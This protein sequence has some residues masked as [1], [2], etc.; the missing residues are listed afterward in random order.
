MPPIRSHGEYEQQEQRSKLANSYQSL[1]NEFSS[2]EL[3]TVGN[4][5][6]GRLIG[7]GSF[8]KVYLASHKLTNGSKVVLKSAKK[9][10]AN[11]AREIHHHRQFLHPHIARLYEVIVTENLVW[12]VLEWCPGDELYNH[13]LNHGRMEPSKVQKIFTQLVGAVSYVHGKSCVHRDLKLENILL[14]KHENV[15]LV[16]FGF[17]RE[18]QGSTS[19]LQ[20]WCGTVCYSAPEM[21]K[22]EKYA[23]E[24]VDVWSLGI[25][26]HALLC[27]ELPWDEDDEAATKQLI[28]KEEPKFP[29][30]VPEQ[31]KELIKKL[32]AKRP[33]LR[34][35]LG[36]ILKDPWL[37]EHSPQQHEILKVQQPPAFSTQ[38]EKDTLQRM[39]SAGVDIDVVIE[40][41]LSQRCDALA[42]WWALLIEKEQRKER[43][44]E[45]KRKEREAEAKSIRRLSAASSRLLAQSALGEIQEGEEAAI[46]GSPSARG[47]RM[48]R[49]NGSLNKRSMDLPRVLETNSPTSERAPRDETVKDSVMRDPSRS[50]SRP[51]PP[52]KDPTI[53]LPRPRPRNVPRSNSMLRYSTVNPDLLSPAYVPPPQRKRRTFYPQ[54]LKEQLA[55]VKHWFKEGAKRAKSPSNAEGKKGKTSPQLG[56]DGTT[57]SPSRDGVPEIQRVLTGPLTQHRKASVGSRPEL[58]QRATMPARPRINT[59]SSTE[60]RSSLQRKRTS[61]S[62]HTITPHSSYRRSSAGL[63][64]RKSTSSSVSSIRSAYH[65]VGGHQHT[66]S[67]ASSTS[68]NSVASPSNLSQAS[69]SRMARSPHASVKVL[70]ATPTNGTFPSGMRVSRRP[71]PGALGSLPTFAEASKNTFNNLAPGSPSLPV[72][73]RRKRS[74]FKGPLS[75]SPS[76]FARTATV[77]NSSRSGSVQGR[78]SGEMIMGITEEDE[79]E[80]E[81]DA[82]F[83]DEDV[84]EV[85]QFG[86]ELVAASRIQ[87]HQVG[88]VVAVGEDIPEPVTPVSVAPPEDLASGAVSPRTVP[89]LPNGGAGPIPLT[90]AALAKMEEVQEHQEAED[91][92]ATLPV[93][94]K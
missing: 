25:I 80:A 9:D 56:S 44:K 39:K 35:S 40:N 79:E 86:P 27:G 59:M 38:V 77:G 30:Y 69:G 8:G 53:V 70:P 41:V 87:L 47:R 28:L 62:P 81:L 26:L 42:G 45:R 33:I 89:L 60:S 22:G 24:K 52:P 17:T 71:L 93:S 72:F 66:Q 82:E 51:P 75:G 29:D 90:A 85:D 64:G 19:Y 58:Q 91:E 48:A 31:A 5:T 32:L 67:K 43:R 37:A 20:T 36:D 6:L 10:D 84:E 61:L 21:L 78:R 54:P 88:P 68:S 34:P 46:L 74:V 57:V 65:S 63:R 14:D 13:L 16:D 73:A 76:G 92:L 15:K 83:E 12:L 55:W 94:I 3:H 50:R 1:L 49:P 11:L 7:K 4:Y 23:G 18:Y 2:K